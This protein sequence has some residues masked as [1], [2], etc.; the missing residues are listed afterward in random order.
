MTQD[1]TVVLK[2]EKDGTELP[3]IAGT[4]PQQSLEHYSMHRPEL[5][6]ATV[7][8]ATPDLK[9]N[10]LIYSVKSTLGTKG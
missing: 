1:L 4:T 7:G 3:L 5:A 6:T 10:K 9:N 2:I 8:E